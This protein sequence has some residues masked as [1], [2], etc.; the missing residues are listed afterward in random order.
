MKAYLAVTASL[1]GLV[2]AVHV[3]RAVVERPLATEPWF[4][5]ITA[6]AAGLCIWGVRLLRR[7]G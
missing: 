5:L 4:I 6:V 2:A 7:A 1:F 3:W